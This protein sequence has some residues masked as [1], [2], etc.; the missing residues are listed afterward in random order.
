MI[1]RRLASLSLRPSSPQLNRLLLSIALLSTPP[2]LQAAQPDLPALGNASS[3]Y[4]SQQQEHALG[5]VWLKQLRAQTQTLNDPL[6]IAF[7]EDLVYRLIPHS[8]VQDNRYEFVIID[9]PELNAFAVPGGIIGINAGIFLYARDEDEL[10]A[11]LAHELAH[12]SQRHFARQIENAERRS[13][14]AMASLLASILLIATNNADAGFA[15]LISTQAAAVQSQLTYSR[16]WEREADR[17]GMRTM[18]SSDFDPY[19][20][21]S[22]F[23]QMLSANRYNKRPPEFLLTHPVTDS[24]ISDAANRTEGLSRKPRHKSFSFLM[25]QQQAKLKYALSDDNR[26]LHLETEL[27]K[28]SDPNQKDALLYSIANLHLQQDHHSQAQQ[29]LAKISNDNQDQPAVVITQGKIL[30]AQGKARDAIAHIRQAYLLRPESH[31]LA[32]SLAKQLTDNGQAT[33][34]IGDLRQW[35]QKRSSDPLIWQ[36]LI[37]TANQ[38][39]DPLLAFRAKAEYFFLNGDKKKALYQLTLAVKQAETQ[40]EFQQQAALSKRLEQMTDSRESL[41]L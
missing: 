14:I 9:Q 2:S 23:Q 40:K 1:Y 26:L 38:A 5:R 39:K 33:D 7:I 19:A 29:T 36:Q 35:T 4:A 27:A 10:A 11:V 15:G 21:P 34:A 22:M 41:N 20:M 25:L 8:E 24:R 17:V 28:A 6:A 16:D 12:L 37:H 3:G 18:A 32:L 31:P 13:P 30:T